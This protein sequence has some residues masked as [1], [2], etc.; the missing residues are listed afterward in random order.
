MP[1]DRR[2]LGEVNGGAET[3]RPE[4]PSWSRSWTRSGRSSE[5]G[6][7]RR[8][9]RSCPAVGSVQLNLL[10]CQAA[11]ARMIIARNERKYADAMY[12]LGL[13]EEEGESGDTDEATR[14]AELAAELA[15][16]QSRKE[17]MLHAESDEEEED[18]EG[19]DSRQKAVPAAEPVAAPVPAVTATVVGR[20]RSAW[21]ISIAEPV[22]FD[23]LL[24]HQDR[25]WG[26]L[27]TRTAEPMVLCHNSPVKQ[28][29]P[30]RVGAS[31]MHESSQLS[32]VRAVERGLADVAPYVFNF[33][34]DSN[35]KSAKKTHR[36]VDPYDAV[37][38]HASPEAHVD[39][40]DPHP[41][42][43][44]SDF[45]EVDILEAQLTASPPL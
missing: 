2:A 10:K 35:R 19:D 34:S 39:I 22:V 15:S 6:L 17:A 43:Q 40:W 25:V 27:A 37:T 16:L 33:Y 9:E 23:A 8:R 42:S 36:R 31:P 3:D 14:V 26:K 38:C 24:R 12:T 45:D 30:P 7:A 44:A 28:P 11:Q 4:K 29:P 20:A 41:V 1:G 21:E 18:A 13:V 32:V 5:G